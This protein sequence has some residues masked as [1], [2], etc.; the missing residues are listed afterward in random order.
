MVSTPISRN[1]F[2]VVE[3]VLWSFVLYRIM[4]DQALTP[5]GKQFEIGLSKTEAVQFELNGCLG[6]IAFQIMLD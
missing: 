6:A 1:Q 5:T 3:I 2:P 4:L